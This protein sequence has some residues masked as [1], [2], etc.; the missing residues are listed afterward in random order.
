MQSTFKRNTNIDWQA[1]LNHFTAENCLV[2]LIL[3]TRLYSEGQ[4]KKLNRENDQ[5]NRD[6][7]RREFIFS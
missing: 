5:A 7:L 3:F 4:L 6:S 1:G 2:S